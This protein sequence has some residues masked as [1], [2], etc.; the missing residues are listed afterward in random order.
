MEKSVQHPFFVPKFA[1]SQGHAAPLLVLQ[2]HPTAYNQVLNQ[3]TTL[4]C[5]RDFLHGY[6]SPRVWIPRA[7]IDSFSCIEKYI[8]NHKFTHAYSGTIIKEMLEE[9]FYIY[10][11]GVDDFYLPGK[12]F[13]GTRHH[14]HDGIICG[15]D[16]NDKTFSIAAYDMNW[17][18]N[19]IRVPQESF[20]I[21][22]QS[23][24][25]SNI[26]GWLTAYKCKDIEVK[27]DEK[28][29][30]HHLIEY[31][32]WDINAFPIDG[33]G[34]VHGTALH[35]YLAMY[36]GKLIDGSI[37]ADKM[38][39]RSLRPFW[40]HKRCMQERIE[41]VEKVR[42]WDSTLST[43]Y[44][45]L[46]ERTNRIRMMYAMFHKNGKFALLESIRREILVLQEDEKI[47][48]QKVIEKMEAK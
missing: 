23:A 30:L 19:L 4:G 20:F 14:H 12:S 31:L 43:E 48:L 18:F 11:N 36:I 13:F 45:A 7:Y 34:R 22:I 6:T 29:I 16:D 2:Q 28:L 33:E 41:A 27:L 42:E 47:I 9:G 38:D 32:N 15:Y 37:P 21:G 39:W 44:A 10:Y 1:C 5:Y 3:C 17:V 8:V 24:L 46:V 40:E 35:D 26:F 25:E